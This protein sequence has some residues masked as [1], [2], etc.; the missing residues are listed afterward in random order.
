MLTF[1]EEHFGQIA[2]HAGLDRHVGDGHHCAKFGQ[3]NRHGAGFNGFNGHGL[4]IT[5][6]GGL[7]HG[8]AAVLACSRVF[9]AMGPEERKS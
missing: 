7:L 1:R 2:F 4:G 5:P 9:P 3:H 6:I 8:V